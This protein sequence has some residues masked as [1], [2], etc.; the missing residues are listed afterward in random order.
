MRLPRSQSCVNTLCDFTYS[1]RIE[2]GDDSNRRSPPFISAPHFSMIKKHKA[3][4]LA[5]GPF[6]QSS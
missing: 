1:T 5:G 2:K 6:F 3:Y 4:P